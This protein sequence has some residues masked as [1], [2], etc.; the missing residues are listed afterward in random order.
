MSG[1][2]SISFVWVVPND[3]YDSF[4]KNL[5]VS[6]S[7]P[8]SNASTANLDRMTELDVSSW[9]YITSIEFIVSFNMELINV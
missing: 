3:Q 1:L 2:N 4:S 8:P 9:Q 5:P 7:P 6:P